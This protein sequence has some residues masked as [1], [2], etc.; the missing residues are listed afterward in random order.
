MTY[1]VFIILLVCMFSVMTIGIGQSS[2]VFTP[3]EK[4][5]IY[6]TFSIALLPAVL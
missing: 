3:E 4:K 2:G 1:L 6:P 5:N